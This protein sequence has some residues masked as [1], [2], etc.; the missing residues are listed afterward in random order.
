[1][2]T[3]TYYHSL[4]PSFP[5]S[6]RIFLT[7][8]WEYHPNMPPTLDDV[9]DLSYEAK[10]WPWLVRGQKS[11]GKRNR[12]LA[13]LLLLL[14]KGGWVKVTPNSALFCPLTKVFQVRPHL[15]PKRGSHRN[16]YIGALE[17]LNR[18]KALV[19]EEEKMYGN[20]FSL[21]IE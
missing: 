10:E 17:T 11:H 3:Q 1:M 9:L 14:L 19:A 13:R 20:G 5:D 12:N 15:L 2:S 4:I 6:K 7:G 16:Q 18:L 8:K 21:Q